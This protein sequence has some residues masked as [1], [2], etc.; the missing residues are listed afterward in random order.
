MIN[1]WIIVLS[2]LLCAADMFLLFILAYS[3]KGKI[4]KATKLGFGFM[5]TVLVLNMLFSIG[6]IVLW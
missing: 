4:N 6:G 2:T 3:S 1:I 5:G